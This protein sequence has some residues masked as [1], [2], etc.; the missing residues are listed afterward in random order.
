[1][2]RIFFVCGFVAL[3]LTT[4]VWAGGDAAA[5]KLLATCWLSRQ[6]GNSAIPSFPKLAGLGENI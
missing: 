6:D 4:P 2:K 1:M 5:G 3:F